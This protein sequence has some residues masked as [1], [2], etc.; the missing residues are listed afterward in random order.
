[1]RNLRSNMMKKI[2]LLLIC[3]SLLFSCRKEAPYLTATP[4]VVEFE[5]SGGTKRVSV[6]CG[7]SWVTSSTGSWLSASK[8]D[9][10]LLLKASRNDTGEERSAVVTL[11][12]DGGLSVEVSVTQKQNDVLVVSGETIL[13]VSDEAQELEVNLTS[14]IAYTFSTDVDWITLKDTKALS[15]GKVV[16]SIAAQSGKSR[17]QGLVSFTADSGAKATLLIYQNG[18]QADLKVSLS[19]VST[20]TVP[21]MTGV[22][23]TG[24]VDWG[25]GSGTEDYSS[26]LT[27]DYAATGDYEVSLKVRN[28]SSVKIS[29]LSGVKSIDLSAL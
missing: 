15:S 22:G 12:S 18:P 1:M 21:T 7:D 6:S 2:F 11:T 4:E 14:N 16:L 8:Q 10:V 13:T 23:F 5:S 24:T 29:N 28:I 17:R 27:H 26:N 20:W 19:G 9:N 25:D 3:A